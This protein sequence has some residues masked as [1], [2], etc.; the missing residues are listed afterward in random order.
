M[1]IRTS[2]SKTWRKA[3]TYVSVKDITSLQER[4]VLKHGAKVAEA[5]EKYRS[6]DEIREEQASLT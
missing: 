1:H 4:S 6:E 5:T 3:T 2:S